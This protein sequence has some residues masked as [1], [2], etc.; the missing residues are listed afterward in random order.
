MIITT[1]SL[2]IAS[3]AAVLALT[4][5]L[6]ASY[7][8]DHNAAGANNSGG[9]MKGSNSGGTMKSSGH[10]ASRGQAP[11]KTGSVRNSG[12][13]DVRQAG[14]SH[15][16]QFGR[17]GGHNKGFGNRGVNIY[18]GNGGCGYSYRK[19]R[20]TGSQY[21]RSRFYDCIG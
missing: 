21:W 10:A 11:A 9:S 5:P 4:T 14:K 1:K 12:G 19:W 3:A 8:A 15:G 18:A 20:A 7:A 16:R 13:K 2:M 17:N 6:S